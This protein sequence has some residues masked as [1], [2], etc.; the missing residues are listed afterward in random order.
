MFAKGLALKLGKPII[1]VNHLEGHALIAGLTDGV[2]PPFVLLLVSGG[3]CQII[4]VEA[5]GQY[6][7]LGKTRD[8]SVGEAFDKVSKMMGLGYP[9]G[10]IIEQ[11]ARFGD[12]YAVALPV[13]LL[14]DSPYDF[15]FSG[16]KT[17]VKRHL[18]GITLPLTDEVVSNVS[19]S[20]QRVVGDVLSNRLQNVM[21]DFAL[22]NGPEDGKSPGATGR[23]KLVISGGVAANQYLLGRIREA[24]R[25]YYVDVENNVVAPPIGLCTDNG[26]MIAW[27]G[28]QHYEAGRS[29]PLSLEPRS[30]WPLSALATK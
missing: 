13:P 15:S 26:I 6:E 17:A 3:H 19:A 29:D 8:D 7:I 24:T 10:P 1:G 9:G 23:Y 28:L 12:P 20:F 2:E 22:M 11:R 14:R 25:E 4:K 21:R 27:A 18:D 30:R 5:L 16:L